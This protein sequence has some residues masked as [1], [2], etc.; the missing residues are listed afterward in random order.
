MNPQEYISS[1]ILESYV[2]GLASEEEI[3]Q[4]QK[5][6][7]TYPEVKREV[8]AI[9]A[10]L[11]EHA[12]LQANA[13]SEELRTKIIAEITGETPRII[14]MN[15]V[16][17]RKSY[18]YK[19]GAAASIILLLASAGLNFYLYRNLKDAKEQVAIL[20]QEKEQIASVFQAEKTRYE[21]QLSAISSPESH[22]VVLKG[23]TLSPKSLATVFWNHESH[24][25]YINV[26]ELPPPPQGKQYQLWALANGQPVDAGV[27]N[28][29][30]TTGLQKMKDITDAQAF[31]VTLENAGG[32]PVPT[33]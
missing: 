8:E 1:G 25:V 18:F 20:N 7:D 32:S 2:L 9:E 12:S 27:F 31:A 17:E 19:Y 23:S 30:D 28:L 10:S 22:A 33:L 11:M 24:E 13:P 16:E 15:N 26:N 6:M 3:R 4:V 14:S 29:G 21:S 5:M